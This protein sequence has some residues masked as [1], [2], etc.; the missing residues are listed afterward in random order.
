M[1]KMLLCLYG[2][3]N[4]GKTSTIKLA[5]DRFK[6][7]H[8]NANVENL[9]PDNNGD[10]IL[11]KVETKVATVGFSS[12]GDAIK[13][14]ERDLSALRDENCDI[15]VCAA[16]ARKVT[17][18]K[19][20]FGDEYLRRRMTTCAFEWR[21]GESGIKHYREK[22]NNAVADLIVEFIHNHIA[23]NS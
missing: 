15:I 3:S 6:E 7:C 17:L 11:V 4:S 1:Q 10:D 18:D 22:C 9:K 23:K 19:V 16:R 8:P 20:N 5:F 12:E 21:G 14:I 13:Q 2:H